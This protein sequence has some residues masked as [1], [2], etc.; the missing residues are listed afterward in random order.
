M[1]NDR[2]KIAIYYDIVSPY[3]YVAFQILLRY[4]KIWNID[5]QVIPVFLGGIMKASHNKP[6]AL[7]PLKG[8]YLYK[9]L[10]RLSEMSHIKLK[11]PQD[12]MT[13]MLQ[14]LKPMRLI[15]AISYYYPNQ[16]ELIIRSSIAFWQRLWRF[17]V[18]IETF[19]ALQEVLNHIGITKL[20]IQKK[21][22]E[23]SQTNPIIKDQLKKNTQQA[24]DSGAFGA[25]WII[26]NDKECF[27]G[28][29]RFHQIAYYLNKPY[30]GLTPPPQSKL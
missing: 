26:V 3:S 1:S 2:C 23:N 27:F 17:D 20:S 29:D 4:E 9:D 11:P 6:P 10:Q 13:R 24:I 15:T 19:T 12:F 28:S 7:V 21:I 8:R 5:L 22:I 18:E 14:S 25:P 30:Y 16:P